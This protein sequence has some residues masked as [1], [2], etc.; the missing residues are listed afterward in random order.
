MIIGIAG[1]S[2][3]GK[4]SLA[5]QIQKWVGTSNSIILS[6][7]NYIQSMDKLYDIS[8]DECSKK[9]KITNSK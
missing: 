9:Y 2:R 8:E 3:A 7:D 4:T 5:M 1:V 6:Q